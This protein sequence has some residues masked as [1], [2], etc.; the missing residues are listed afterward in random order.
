M[1]P[2]L[3]QSL[4]DLRDVSSI[5]VMAD[6]LMDSDD[7]KN[8]ELGELLRLSHYYMHKEK[9]NQGEADRML[10]LMR[11]ILSELFHEH[12][13]VINNNS[14]R[15]RENDTYSVWGNHIRRNGRIIKIEDVNDPVI[16]RAIG[17]IYADMMFNA[18]VRETGIE[19]PGD[20]RKRNTKKFEKKKKEITSDKGD[21]L[22]RSYLY[23]FLYSVNR[24]ERNFYDIGRL[25]RNHKQINDVRNRLFYRRDD[26]SM[27][28]TIEKYL[29]KNDSVFL[30]SLLPR[31]ISLRDRLHQFISDQNENPENLHLNNNPPFMVAL[32]S[33]IEVLEKSFEF[34]EQT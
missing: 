19:F 28:Y 23:D 1:H 10:S 30:R 21:N 22:L 4:E 27:I 26:E 15:T 34:N 3:S 18:T 13:I 33:V 8:H 2:F 16:L 6:A 9:Y 24:M 12:G 20:Y 17:Y 29:Q 32:N 7:P 14:L 31:L 25:V 5:A 11:K